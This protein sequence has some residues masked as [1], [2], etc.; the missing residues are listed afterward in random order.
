MEQLKDTVE[1]KAKEIV[2]LLNGFSLGEGSMVLSRAE[3]LIR[4]SA[5]IDTNSHPSLSSS[6]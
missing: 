1:K 5:I 6:E 3:I 2:K 4:E